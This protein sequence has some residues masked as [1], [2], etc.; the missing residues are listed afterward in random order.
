[1]PAQMNKTYVQ[2]A[3]QTGELV[4][5][6]K[7]ALRSAKIIVVAQPDEQSATLSL[8]ESSGRRV[9]SVGADGVALEYEIYYTV[10]FRV[11]RDSE[12]FEIT[13]QS[14]TLTRDY[15]FDRLGVLAANEEEAALRQDMQRELA[16]LVI[17]RIA[18]AAKSDAVSAVKDN[19]G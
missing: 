3:N 19:A 14:I 10:T 13:E 9:L 12:P 11:F 8:S 18:A 2:A 5:Q 15:V 17:D 7:R 16:R 6:L 1:M 4:R